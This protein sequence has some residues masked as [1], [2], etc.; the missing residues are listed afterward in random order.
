[1]L[2]SRTIREGSV[3]L[4]ALIGIALFGAVALWLR[5]INFTEKS[6]QVIAQFPNV[7]GIQVGDSVRYRGLKVGKITD[8]MPGTNGVD[9]MMEISSS[10]LLI[11]K[12]ALIQASS[13]GL[14]GETFVAI[15]PQNQLPDQA[16]ATNPLSQNCDSSLIICNNDRL[17]GQPGITLDDLMPLMYQM[18]TLYS[19]PRFFDNINTAVQ[20]TSMA[21][22]EATQLSRDL[23]VLVK[24]LRGQLKTFSNTANAITKVAENSSEQIASTAEQYK[25]TANQISELTTSVNQLVTQNRSNLVATLDN[26]KTTSD[27]L[28]NLT[29]QIDKSLGNTNTEQLVQNLETLTANAAEASANL[30]DISATFSNPNNLV[31]LQ[32]TLDSARVTFVNAQK[33][34]ADLEQITG[35]PAFVNNVKNLVNGLGNLVSS[36]EQLEQQVQTTQIL[37]P[38]QQQLSLGSSTDNFNL[39]EKSLKLESTEQNVLLEKET[40][41]HLNSSADFPVPELNKQPKRF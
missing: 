38:V 32:Q 1:M 37:E 12:N 11:P 34:T 7:N 19:D 4:L 16:Q 13:S 9:V 17:E 3:G 15:I 14:I 29:V 25:K 18:S 33:I 39:A 30:K 8:I 31:T 2:R 20:N 21:A 27:R 5:G 26:I 10:D 6:Y 41:F 35:D 40:N 28:Q 24:D 23:S 36:T 22:G